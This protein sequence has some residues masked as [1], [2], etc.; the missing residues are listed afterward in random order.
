MTLF[1]SQHAPPAVR[2]HRPAY[3]TARSNRPH[4]GYHP[5]NIWCVPAHA[6]HEAHLTAPTTL[7]GATCRRG[8]GGEAT[9]QFVAE[10]AGGAS[11]TSTASHRIRQL[12]L[13][14]IRKRIPNSPGIYRRSPKAGSSTRNDCAVLRSRESISRRPHNKASARTAA[15]RIS[16]GDACEMRTVYS[17][18]KLKNRIRR[19]PARSRREV[20]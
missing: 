10:I 19:S 12:A 5:G 6:G 15:R 17:P 7:T 8:E 2:H 1:E 9:R 18:T 16:T 4:H 11:N 14:P 13:R 3:A 20:L